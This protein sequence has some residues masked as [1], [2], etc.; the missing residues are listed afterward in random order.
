MILCTHLVILGRFL[1][2]FICTFF[3]L[4][5][6]CLFFFFFSSVIYMKSI[7][8]ILFCLFFIHLLN[9]AWTEFVKVNL[10]FK[11]VTILHG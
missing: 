1:L 8:N 4:V 5:F 10:S 6:F 7:S 3:Y 2:L 9:I 11:I